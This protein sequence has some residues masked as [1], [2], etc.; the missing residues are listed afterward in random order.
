MPRA[1]VYYLLAFLPFF[2][3]VTRGFS[4]ML[5][6]ISPLR[7]RQPPCAIDFFDVAIQHDLLFSSLSA[8]RFLDAAPPL[9]L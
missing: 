9:S 2:V 8:I 5:P 6:V 1:Y 4:A 3:Q 7:C